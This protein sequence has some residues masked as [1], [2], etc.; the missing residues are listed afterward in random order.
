[1]TRSDYKR[2]ISLFTYSIP[3]ASHYISF[4]LNIFD[5]EICLK[6]KQ[7][8]EQYTYF[9]YFIFLTCV[10]PC[11]SRLY[12][13]I[14]RCVH[15]RYFGDMSRRFLLIILITILLEKLASVKD[16][17]LS[18]LLSLYGFVPVA[19]RKRNYNF[20]SCKSFAKYGIS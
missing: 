15:T 9:K 19:A 11:I 18:K 17:E 7:N 10:A 16:R 6:T 5:V 4:K 2:N 14:F 20:L 12:A 3:H 8:Q 1:M 13:I